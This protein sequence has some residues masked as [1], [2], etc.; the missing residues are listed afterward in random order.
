MKNS[1]ALLI[2][3]III[4]TATITVL[5]KNS[6]LFE[7][8]SISASYINNDILDDKASV[9]EQSSGSG[10]QVATSEQALQAALVQ[11]SKNM[12]IESTVVRLVSLNTLADFQ[13]MAI[14]WSFLGAN[15]NDPVWLIAATSNST[16]QASD[17]DASLSHNSPYSGGFIALSPSDGATKAFGTI[18]TD[19]T[20][21]FQVEN[22]SNEFQTVTCP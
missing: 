9:V 11:L 1:N 16:I 7:S 6:K 18:D 14:N 22:M 8:G 19:M 5:V 10:C 2:S 13:H 20:R 17:I 15:P 12:E 21:Y 4:L 3:L